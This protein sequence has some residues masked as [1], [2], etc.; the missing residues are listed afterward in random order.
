MLL[1]L[2]RTVVPTSGTVTDKLRQD[3]G[4][5]DIMK[6]LNW[7]KYNQLGLT[8]YEET[9]DGKRIK[10]IKDWSKRNDQRH[11]AMDAI[12]IAFT[13]HNHIQYLNNLNTIYNLHE[14][15]EVQHDK[16]NLYGIKEKITELVEDKNG[17]KKRKFKKPMPNLRSEAK[18]H[19]ENILVS[20]KAKNK[21]VTQNKNY[22][23]V[24][25]NNP[26]KNKIKRK[27]KHYL[28]QD[29]LT[30]RGQL[31]NET[32]YGKIKQPLKKPVKLS[33]KFT[34]KQAELIINKEI[35]QT[36]L[37]HLAKYNNKHEIA[38]E[39]KTLKKDPVIFNNKPLKE[40]HCFEEFYTIRK[41]ISP[42]LKIDKVID[43]KAK[44]ILETRLKE[45][46]GN[47]KE[48]FA[49][50]DKNPIWLNKEKGIAIKKVTIKGINNAEVLHTKKDHFGKEILDEN[51]HPVPADF[52]NTGNN[53]HVAI[54]R[55]KDGNLHEKVV[56][57]FEAVERANQGMPIIDKDYKKGL[58]W[59]LLFTLK[60]NEMFV[61]P[62]PETGFNPSEIDLLNP[63]NKSLI[64]P[65]LFRVQ[66]IGSSDYWFRHHLETNIK[67]NIK[68]IT[69]FRITNKNTLQNIKKV[70]INHTGKIVA[71]GEY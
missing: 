44:K 3:W 40:V 9:K 69:Y 51:N 24:S 66:K 64:S 36:V 17:N 4:L 1:K 10:I 63:N 52:V 8:D 70:R 67:N 22:I 26:R 32:I 60:Q 50:L 2:V 53:H 42:D 48:A 58:G 11:H 47:A 54:Y 37:N 55:D 12:T 15:E 23:K 13:T 28:V 16:S 20:Y 46:N 71:V 35:K 5:V 62:N 21:V 59:E 19:L 65:N 43:E 33:K 30:P 68:G 29:T 41:D 18:K 6:E 38:F 49:N 56:S 27:G 39:S 14:Q 7:D 57:F 25:A 61:F 34:A 45:Y 31:H